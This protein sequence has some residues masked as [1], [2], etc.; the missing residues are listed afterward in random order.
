MPGVLLMTDSPTSTQA[1]AKAE[2]NPNPYDG[3]LAATNLPAQPNFEQPSYPGL[4]EDLPGR[5]RQTGDRT[6]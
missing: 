5:T 1:N 6:R 2:P 3:M 4:R